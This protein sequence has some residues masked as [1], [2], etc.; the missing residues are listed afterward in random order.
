MF[1]KKDL[2]KVEEF[3]IMT[4]K[5]METEQVRFCVIL[6]HAFLALA[7]PFSVYHSLLRTW[8]WISISK[9]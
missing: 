6:H 7:S 5:I 8:W 2:K 1:N 3:R 4:T 9:I